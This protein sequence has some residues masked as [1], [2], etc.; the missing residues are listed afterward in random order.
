M[1]ACVSFMLLGS[2][3]PLALQ[4]EVTDPSFSDLEAGQRPSSRLSKR[5]SVESQ[6]SRSETPVLEYRRFSGFYE[7]RRANS[8][9]GGVLSVEASARSPLHFSVR[10]RRT[11]SA[12]PAGF[13]L[14]VVHENWVGA[15]KGRGKN[16]ASEPVKPSRPVTMIELGEKDNFD[17]MKKEKDRRSS[18]S[19]QKKPLYGLFPSLRTSTN[20]VISSRLSTSST[21]TPSHPSRSL[22]LDARTSSTPTVPPLC[23][24]TEEAAFTPPRRV[25]SETSIRPRARSHTRSAS[26][27]HS[28]SQSL[29]LNSLS[30]STL[31]SRPSLI[32]TPALSRSS[33]SKRVSFSKNDEIIQVEDD[34]VEESIDP[35]E[36]GHGSLRRQSSWSGFLLI[37]APPIA[38]KPE[39]TR[40]ISM[41]AARGQAAGRS[42]LRRT[43]SFEVLQP[44]QQELETK[45]ARKH[46]QR[47]ATG[48]RDKSPPPP[49]SLPSLPEDEDDILDLYYG[50]VDLVSGSSASASTSTLVSNSSVS[51]SRSSFSQ[52]STSSTSS[53]TSSTNT[54]LLEAESDEDEEDVPPTPFTTPA[55]PKAM[56]FYKHARKDLQIV[57]VP[58]CSTSGKIRFGPDVDLSARHWSMQGVGDWVRRSGAFRMVKVDE[59]AEV[60]GGR[61]VVDAV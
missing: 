11:N 19:V 8:S 35:S 48:R 5:A 9:P 3:I 23:T 59:R 45:I 15:E 2:S 26:I 32:A 49:T 55:T 56:T 12:P 57:S 58:S 52:S 39:L 44:A 4:S 37:G 25:H 47:T 7:H 46:V 24:L 30:N 14:P 31:N 16:I 50:D 28:R 27:S 38:A 41:P 13:T 6:P 17:Q 1:A 42:I 18:A 61:R 54:F 43:S 29:T 21:L 34:V 22:S 20:S 10:P 60:V 33:S 40:R 53:T 36:P 51:P